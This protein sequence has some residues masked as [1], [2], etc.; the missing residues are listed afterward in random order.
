MNKKFVCFVCIALMV[1]GICLVHVDS[2]CGAQRQEIQY[3]TI[4]N[5]PFGIFPPEDIIIE[6]I[7]TYI[8]LPDDH[9]EYV[10]YFEGKEEF[11]EPI[12]GEIEKLT[13]TEEELE[14][15]AHIIFAEAGSNWCS[16]KMQQYTGSVVLNRI[17]SPLFPNTMK[18][19]I[20]QPSQYSCVKSGSYYKTPNE[21]AYNVARFL[22]ENGSVLPSNV[23]FQSQFM[24]GDGLYEKVQ[25][26]YF[27]YKN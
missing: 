25:N 10:E 13:Y 14:M 24:Q 21:R 7:V 15:L 11:V 26:M 8:D 6:E 5:M 9:E 23:V 2:V 22:L 16:D 27:C 18:E 4:G 3:V 12:I 19:V 20:Y 1:C 17:A